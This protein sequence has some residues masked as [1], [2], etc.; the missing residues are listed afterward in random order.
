MGSHFHILLHIPADPP[1]LEDAARRYNSYYSGKRA[2]LEPDDP[3]CA[4][5]ALKLRDIS[6]YMKALQQ[7]FTRWFNRTRGVR[8][9]GHLWADRFKN[10]ILENGLAVWD[11]WKYIEMNPVRARMV[12]DPADYRFSSFGYWSAKGKHPFEATVV[13]RLMPVFRGLLHISNMED[14]RIQMKKDFAYYTALESGASPDRVDAAIA[15]AAEKEPFSTQLDR[16]VRYWVDGLVIGSELFVR[17]TVA[18]GRV[19]Y[20]VN[21]RRLTR[22][23]ERTG[24][25]EPLY[26]F[27]QLRFLLE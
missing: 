25:K 9:R 21:R 14:L 13:R 26:S 5:L 7:P 22:A 23:V 15:V 3:K 6:E 16:R 20:K 4:E 24:G 2:P 27:K 8:R 10:T 17:N 12:A 1:S 11:W 18:A 19:R